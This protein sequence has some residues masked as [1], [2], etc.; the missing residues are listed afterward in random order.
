MYLDLLER[1]GLVHAPTIRAELAKE[2]AY[3]APLA[4]ELG[5]YGVFLEKHP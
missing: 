3:F 2:I 5:E 4:G 1:R